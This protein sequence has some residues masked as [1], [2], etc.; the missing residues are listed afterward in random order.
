M[1]TSRKS[2][3]FNGFYSVRNE[4]TLD[5]GVVEEGVGG[6][7]GGAVGDGA[8]PAGIHHVRRVPA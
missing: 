4:D 1:N 2:T 8:E 3:R 5:R 6:D 7:A